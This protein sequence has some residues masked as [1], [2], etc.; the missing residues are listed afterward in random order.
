[1]QVTILVHSWL[2]PT[3]GQLKHRVPTCV[4]SVWFLVSSEC[5]CL[6]AYFTT[7]RQLLRLCVLNQCLDYYTSLLAVNEEPK[8]FLN[9]NW[10]GKYF[11]ISLFHDASSTAQVI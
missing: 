10:L 9:T 5:I 11:V 3:Y 2:T 1:M 6:L 8:S 7:L 4:A